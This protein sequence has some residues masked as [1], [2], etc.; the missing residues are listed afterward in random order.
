VS[1]VGDFSSRRDEMNREHPVTVLAPEETDILHVPD[2]GDA[3]GFTE[4]TP[5]RWLQEKAEAALVGGLRHL[6]PDGSSL[7]D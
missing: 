3:P 6:P 4:G 7:P 5:G 1:I 2:A